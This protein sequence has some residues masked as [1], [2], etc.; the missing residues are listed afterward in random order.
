MRVLLVDDADFGQDMAD[1]LKTK[2]QHDVH[3]VNRPDRAIRYLGRAT[4]DVLVVDV[5]FVPEMTRFDS[6]CREGR[7]SP[8]DGP[9][10]RTCLAVLGDAGRTGPAASVIWTEGD[11]RRMLHMRF[12]QERLGVRVFADKNDG[13]GA[14][15]GLHEAILK[16]GRGESSVDRRLAEEGIRTDARYTTSITDSL[17]RPPVRAAVWRALALG[18]TKYQDVRDAVGLSMDKTRFARLVDGMATDSDNLN[19]R[20][21]AKPEVR[22]RA[23]LS[24]LTAFAERHRRFL[25]DDYIK[26]TFD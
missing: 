17:F 6:L 12:A 1:M 21:H 24:F 25:L 20:P 2:Y 13:R 23:K 22:D 26:K 9:F 15:P 4:Y 16:A 5:L 18:A 11:D 10:L 14:V 19:A 7:V 3:Y 8:V